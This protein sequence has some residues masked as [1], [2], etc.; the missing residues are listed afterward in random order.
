MSK[1]NI[2]LPLILLFPVLFFFHTC[3]KN[4]N[5]FEPSPNQVRAGIKLANNDIPALAGTTELRSGEKPELWEV[6]W[7]D[8]KKYYIV[9]FVS[10]WQQTQNDFIDVDLIVTET[11]D[12][13][14]HYLLETREHCSLPLFLLEPEDSPAVAGDISYGNGRQFIRENIIIDI[15]AEGNFIEKI[16]DIAKQIDVILLKSPT[17]VTADHMKPIINWFEIIQN[18]V[19]KNSITRLNIDVKDPMNGKIF[20]EWRFTPGLENHGGIEIDDS[21]KIS[22]YADLENSMEELT[23]FAI[24]EYGF[25]STATIYIQIK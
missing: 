7:K 15:H 4:K 13:A 5:P 20:Y 21:G 18:P 24:N 19:K 9:K 16:S 14:C 8:E 10:S 17:A 6:N 12:L 11:H 1:F 22:Y 23:L 25:F 2:F 3:S